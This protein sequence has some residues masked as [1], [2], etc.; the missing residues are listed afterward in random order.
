MIYPRL[1]FQLIILTYFQFLPVLFKSMPSVCHFSDPPVVILFLFLLFPHILVLSFP[2]NISSPTSA[3]YCF[4]A[5]ILSPQ[6]IMRNGAFAQENVAKQISSKVAVFYPGQ[7]DMYL[8]KIYCNSN[9]ETL[10]DE[11]QEIN[12]YSFQNVS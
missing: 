4:T 9:N 2:I 6:H 12:I 7:M 8:I 3:G 10:M 5:S 1:Y 11:S